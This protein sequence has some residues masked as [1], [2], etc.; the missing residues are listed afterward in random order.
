MKEDLVFNRGFFFYKDQR[1]LT[2]ECKMGSFGL[3]L[4]SKDISEWKSTG[5]YN[6]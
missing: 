2:C 4:T 5:I 1:Y 3:G 6:Y